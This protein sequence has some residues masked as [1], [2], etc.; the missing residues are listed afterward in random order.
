M[1]DLSRVFSD[2]R[3]VCTNIIS[4]EGNVVNTIRN[5]VKSDVWVATKEGEYLGAFYLQLPEE[6]DFNTPIC[7]IPNINMKYFAIL[8][9]SIRVDYKNDFELLVKSTLEKEFLP[10][11]EEARFVLRSRDERG[12]TQ[13]YYVNR[14]TA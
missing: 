5:V 12:Y 4:R 1:L 2:S 14:V 7:I 8:F 6:Y 10:Y 11:M 3:G 13:F 9:E